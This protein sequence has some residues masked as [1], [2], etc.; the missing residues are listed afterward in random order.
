LPN[1]G[2]IEGAGNA[3][4]DARL[5]ISGNG[6]Y[7][8]FMSDRDLTAD[9]SMND[10]YFL[11]CRDMLTGT[12]RYVGGTPATSPIGYVAISEN[13]W[14]VAF[15]TNIVAPDNQTIWIYDTELDAV[16]AGY[17]YEQSPAP[18]GQRQGLSI[19]NDGRFVAFALNSVALTG[20]TFDQVV[21]I[22]LENTAVPILASTGAGGAGDGNSA[23]PQISGDGRYVLFESQ[24]P[25]LTEGLGL[26][27]RRYAVVRDLVAGT[28]RIA[29]HAPN[30]A[31]VELSQFGT[32]AISSDGSIVSFATAQVYAEPR[33]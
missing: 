17:T 25:N 27:W 31:P 16:S 18:A 15:T 8:A 6:R 32:H 2:Q 10:G 19:S 9:G 14:F 20:S 13:G 4:Y 26:S 24:A 23:Y 12:T 28:T 5:A 3:N 11:Y 22:D 21:V 29:S 30:G 33:P 7:V 1:G